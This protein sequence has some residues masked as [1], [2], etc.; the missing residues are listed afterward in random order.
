[1]YLFDKPAYLSHF[2]NSDKTTKEVSESVTPKR[3]MVEDI[4]RGHGTNTDK[5][6]SDYPASITKDSTN[7]ISFDIGQIFRQCNDSGIRGHESC[8]ERHLG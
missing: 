2:R 4:V 3:K 7:L 1:M 8:N 5:I 6:V